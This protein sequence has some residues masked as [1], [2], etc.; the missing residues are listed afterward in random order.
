MIIPAVLGILYDRQVL[1]YV[2]VL[3]YLLGYQID[4]YY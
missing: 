3:I 2:D 1:F 4:Y